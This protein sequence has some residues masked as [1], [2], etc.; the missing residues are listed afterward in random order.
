MVTFLPCHK[1]ILYRLFF[2]VVNDLCLHIG[3]SW[4]IKETASSSTS[5]LEGQD[6]SLQKGSSSYAAFPKQVSSY[7]LSSLFKGE[8][9]RIQYGQMGFPSRVSRDN[10]VTLLKSFSLKC[11]AKQGSS[12]LSSVWECL[13]HWSEV[14]D[15]LVQ[16]VACSCGMRG[17]FGDYDFLKA[18]FHRTA[19]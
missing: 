16:K 6:S 7:S 17:G 9:P 10:C 11:I 5:S 1:I 3:I 14:G 2:S 18:R 19:R 4:S 15:C 13:S 8:V 12:D